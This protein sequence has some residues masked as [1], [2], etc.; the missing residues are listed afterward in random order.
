[1][2]HKYGKKASEKIARVMS[3]FE[4]GT[5]KSSSG[6]KV[7]AREQ[8]IAI[9]I[10]EARARG[11]KVPPEPKRQ[12]SKI[13]SERSV[14]DR[15]RTYLSS[16][17]P[18]QEIDGYGMARVLRDVDPLAAGYALEHAVKAGLAATEDGKW[19]GPAVGSGRH[20][21]TMKPQPKLGQESRDWKSGFNYG[22]ESTRH[23][24]RPQMREVLRELHAGAR[25]DFDRGQ[26]AAYE[27]ALGDSPSRHHSTR[28]TAADIEREAARGRAAKPSARV[29]AYPR[30]RY[31]DEAHI[32]VTTTIGD[33]AGS[34]G[35]AYTA[36]KNVGIV[37]ARSSA[38]TIRLTLDEGLPIARAKSLV[39]STLED[40][41]IEVRQ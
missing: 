25:T 22:W 2:A 37:P 14:D 21:T 30:D 34:H 24:T 36:L 15:V 7:T 19:F 39:I 40:A 33:L 29:T 32:D 20:H 27:K 26:L 31:V 17:S 35:R 10:S 5:L 4:R 16:L 13:R 8:A 41:G 38:G 18:G 28:A 1:M 11:Y 12:H 9:G 3:E 23:E 6:R